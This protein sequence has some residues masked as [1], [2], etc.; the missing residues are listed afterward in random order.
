MLIYLK[1]FININI[2]FV[3]SSFIMSTIILQLSPANF[4]PNLGPQII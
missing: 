4:E 3:N 1:Y 2:L